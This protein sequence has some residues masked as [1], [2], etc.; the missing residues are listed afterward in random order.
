[1]IKFTGHFMVTHSTD[2]KINIHLEDDT[3]GEVV[4]T[5][6]IDPKD[7]ALATVSNRMSPCTFTY[8][9]NSPIGKV[10]EGQVIE[11][12]LTSFVSK[13]E[14]KK[15]VKEHFKASKMAD[16]G[17]K[18]FSDGTSTQQNKSGVHQYRLIRFVDKGE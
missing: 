6:T 5:I 8:E 3:S 4:T 16:D 11:M 1:M 10:R 18:M 2:N 9:P 7:F 13:D 17:W 14:R 15:L 12:P